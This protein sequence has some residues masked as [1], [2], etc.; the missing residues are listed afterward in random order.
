MRCG[1]FSAALA[2]KNY[3]TEARE[4]EAR[5][6]GR[7]VGPGELRQIVAHARG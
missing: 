1:A 4:L 3:R 2:A 7:R 6:A 5:W